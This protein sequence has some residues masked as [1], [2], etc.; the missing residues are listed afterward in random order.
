MTTPPNGYRPVIPPWAQYVFAFTFPIVVGTCIW[1]LV[2]F[3]SNPR[4]VEGFYSEEAKR[5]VES[6]EKVQ[7]QIKQDLDS[8]KVLVRQMHRTEDK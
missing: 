6:L 5:R 2:R 1:A 7:G 3:F 4:P 8:I